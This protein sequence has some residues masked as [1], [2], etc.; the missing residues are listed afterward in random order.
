MRRAFN[1]CPVAFDKASP[2]AK[3]KS[4]PDVTFVIGHRGHERVPQL[5]ATLRSISAQQNAN[6][7]T[8][9]V[10]QST[11]PEIEPSLPGDVRYVHLPSPIPDSPYCRARAFNAGAM[12]ALGPILVLHDNDL[13]VP[14]CYAAE[15]LKRAREGY[16]VINLKRFIFYLSQTHTEQ[17]LESASLDF[18]EPPKSIMQNA[19]GG[20]SL[21]ISREAYSAIGG[22]DE[23]FLGWGG[24]DNEFWQRAQTRS[25]WPYGYLPLL[26]LWHEAQSEKGEPERNTAALLTARSAIPVDER[27]NELRKLNFQ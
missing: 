26:H 19:E 18:S 14:Q 4:H 15:I 9:V 16:E 1:D 27:I 11:L 25:V 5:L 22:F 6:V 12:L 21:A 13:L 10:D 17:A 24:E 3:A 7:E 23:A 8:L 20:G 2:E